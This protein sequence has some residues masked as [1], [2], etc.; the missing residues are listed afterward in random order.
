MTVITPKKVET[1]SL[2]DA[3]KAKWGE[4]RILDEGYLPLPKRLLRC[5]GGLFKGPSGIEELQTVLAIIDYRRPN[6]S[7]PPSIQ[8]L[9]AVAGLPV[10][11]FRRNTEAMASKDWLKISGSDEAYDIVLDGFFQEILTLTD[12]G[13]ETVSQSAS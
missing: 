2:P 12:S 3:V 13:Q 8:Y 11:E 6:L 9:A 10:E 7:R 1:A 4:H 5:L